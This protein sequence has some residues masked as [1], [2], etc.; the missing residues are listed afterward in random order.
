M[1][2]PNLPSFSDNC[3]SPQDGQARGFEP[4]RLSAE[5]CAGREA[6]S[7]LSSTS[8][9]RRSLVLVDGAGE[10]APEIAQ[11][12]LPVD[13]AVRDLVELLF[14]I[15]GEIV[16]DIA[17]EEALEEGGDEP[18]L[19]LGH[20][21]ASCRCAHIRDRVSTASV[22]GIGRRAADAE[23]FHALDQ[24]RLGEARRRLGEML[25]SLRSSRAS[26]RRRRHIGGRR[27]RFL[28]LA[29]RRGLPG[30]ARGS[31]RSGRP[32]R[33]RADRAARA[34]ASASMSTVV[35]SSSAD[36]IWLA[37]R[38]LPDQL[39]ELRLLGLELR[40]RHRFGRRLEVGRTDRLVRFLGVLRLGR[41]VARRVRQVLRRRIRLAMTLARA[42]D[43]LGRHVDAVGAHIGDQADGLAAD[44]DAL[45]EALRDLHGARWREAELARGLLL[46]RRGGEGRVRVALRGLRLDRG[47]A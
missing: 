10:I 30:R 22:D 46:Q 47:D 9:V 3:P 23:L 28:V 36:S 15:G 44:V 25:A 17:R 34:P 45:V 5:R 41:V 6:R 38:A 42:G 31:R 2:A 13:L 8:V 33:W 21:A 40:V 12:L 35:R 1:K 29:R 39:V 24:R 37:M 32:G 18:A 16:F 7:R 11:H 14:E 27:P 26:A 43:R 20:R 19:V 4:S